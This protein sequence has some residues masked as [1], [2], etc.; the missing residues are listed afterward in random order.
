MPTLATLQR[1]G[2]RRLTDLAANE[3]V[4]QLSMTAVV[5]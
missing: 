4:T 5:P 1:T 2:P 3:G